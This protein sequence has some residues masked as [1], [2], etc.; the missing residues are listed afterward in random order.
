MSGLPRKRLEI[1]GVVIKLVFVFVVHDFA[2]FER[3]MMLLENVAMQINPLAV[4][5]NAA[6]I[7]PGISGKTETGLRA[8]FLLLSIERLAAKTAFPHLKKSPP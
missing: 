6:M 8:K 2:V 7:R 3:A 4:N 5:A 1:R